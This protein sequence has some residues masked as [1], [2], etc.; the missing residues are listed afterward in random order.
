MTSVVSTSIPTT[1]PLYSADVDAGVGLLLITCFVLGAVGNTLALGYFLSGKR[2]TSNILYLSIVAVDLVS[3]GLALCPGL[4]HFEH[5]DP[6]LLSSPLFCNLWG[7]FFFV[8]SRLSVFL[9]AVLSVSRTVSLLSPFTADRRSHVL[10]PILVYTA[11]LFLVSFLP[12]LYHDIYTYSRSIVFCGWDIPDHHYLPIFI[13]VFI[14][15]NILPFFPVVLSCILSVWEL[16]RPSLSAGYTN[17]GRGEEKRFT[18]TTIVIL[19]SIY[20]L[21]NLPVVV[22]SLLFVVGSMDLFSNYLTVFVFVYN[23]GINAA[24]NPVVYLCRFRGFRKYLKLLRWGGSFRRPITL[25][26]PV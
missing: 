10:T 23:V 13:S 4:S 25:D 12:Y 22:Y 7:V 9:V 11:L 2:T 18:S 19:T 24:V 15:L 26:S 6:L 3:I 21:L 1:S 14:L 20:L 5:R 17:K 8:S 16:S